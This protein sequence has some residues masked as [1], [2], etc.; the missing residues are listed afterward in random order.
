M[1]LLTAGPGGGWPR[2][3]LYGLSPYRRYSE[4][5]MDDEHRANVAWIRLRIHELLMMLS[6]F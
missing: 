4:P 3:S 1:E 5:D 2:E 6:G